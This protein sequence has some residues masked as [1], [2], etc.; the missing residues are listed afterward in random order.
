M[1]FP[2]VQ[3][4]TTIDRGNN[5][6]VSLA[7]ALSL[8]DHGLPCFP[9]GIAKKP[10]RPRGFKDATRNR[11]AVCELWK[12]YPGPLVGVPTGEISGLDVLDIDPR[13]GGHGWLAE[14]K[15]NLP[16]TRVHRTRSGGLHLLFQH[17]HGMRCS[18]GR[19]AAGVDV[20]ATGGYVIWWPAAGLPVLSDVPV[21]AW[22]GW[23]YAQLMSRPRPRTQRV[24]I[25]DQYV[26][27]R[28]VQLIARA[29]EG[30]R[31]I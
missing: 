12:R 1:P 4:V 10:A 13:H 15:H 24:T 22:P 16:S 8:L 17:Q 27:M 5:A 26:L 28:L 21:V 19:I 9:C 3:F 11:D 20:R 6:S 2:S 31:T 18:S 30:E 23:L 29:R 25:P 7:R 14:H